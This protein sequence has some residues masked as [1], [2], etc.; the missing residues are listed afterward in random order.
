MAELDAMYDSVLTNGRMTNLSSS[1]DLV[2]EEVNPF[3]I[4]K[5]IETV[6]SR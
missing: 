3:Y 1:I 6:T 5:R 2:V 4:E